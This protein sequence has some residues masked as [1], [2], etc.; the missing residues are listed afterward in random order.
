LFSN[1]PPLLFL[2]KKNLLP[3]P[4]SVADEKKEKEGEKKG[5]AKQKSFSFISSSFAASAV[6]NESCGQIYKRTI[7]V[8]TLQ[9]ERKKE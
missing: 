6:L 3:P 7:F 2:G 5:E 4:A 8:E 1:L 9:S